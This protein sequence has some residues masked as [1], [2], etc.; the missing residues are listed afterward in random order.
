MQLFEKQSHIR[1]MKTIW[2]QL[3]FSN[4][5]LSTPGFSKAAEKLKGRVLRD[6]QKRNQY[7]K[8]MIKNSFD[9]SKEKINDVTN[10]TENADT[11]RFVLLSNNPSKYIADSETEDQMHKRC[12]SYNN[13][14]HMKAVFESDNF[15]E[16]QA[17][18]AFHERNKSQVAENENSYVPLDK[19]LRELIFTHHQP[20]QIPNFSSYYSK[21]NF[22]KMSKLKPQTAGIAK[23]SE[24]SRKI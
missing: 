8:L 17:K 4:K 2:K 13:H 18:V 21:E 10:H 20:T 24:N 23:R 9:K 22:N 12:L 1:Q 5:N 15:G 16:Y 3:K 6:S 7:A 14:S 11:G 19:I